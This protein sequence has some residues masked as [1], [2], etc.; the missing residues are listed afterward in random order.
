MTSAVASMRLELDG[1][2]FLSSIHLFI[3]LD[4]FLRRHFF[5]KILCSYRPCH[6]FF[7]NDTATTE[8]YTLS[9]HDALPISEPARQPPETGGGPDRRHAARRARADARSERR[10]AAGGHARAEGSHPA[11]AGGGA[12]D[13]GGRGAGAHAGAAAAD[14]GHLADGGIFGPRSAPGRL[15]GARALPGRVQRAALG[16]GHCGGEGQG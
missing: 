13:G 6:F 11:A 8:I 9:L 5:I 4:L 1:W 14:E 16:H 15:A 10:R 12:R 3:T 7:F 2:K